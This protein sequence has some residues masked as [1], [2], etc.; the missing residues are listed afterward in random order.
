[1]TAKNGKLRDSATLGADC[2]VEVH[3]AA[4][5]NEQGRPMLWFGSW[6]EG[7]NGREGG[8]F[9]SGAGGEVTEHVP[10]GEATGVRVRR[11]PS[12]GLD[13]EYADLPLAGLRV[14]KTRDLDFDAPGKR[15]DWLTATT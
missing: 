9:F 14:L 7:E 1:V 15:R 2:P 10:P 4:G 5:T 8:W 11:W 3:W 12:D 6:L 13:P